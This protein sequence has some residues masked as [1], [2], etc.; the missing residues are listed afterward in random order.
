MKNKLEKTN[1]WKKYVTFN[2]P[3]FFRKGVIDDNKNYLTEKQ[4]KLIDLLLIDL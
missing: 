2:T 4:S 1:I 3:V